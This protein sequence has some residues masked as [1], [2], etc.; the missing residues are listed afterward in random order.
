MCIRDRFPRVQE[1]V[2]SG[3]QSPSTASSL[4]AAGPPRYSLGG[5]AHGRG[6]TFRGLQL[7]WGR[8]ESRG[9]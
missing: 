3:P 8:G 7:G 1:R 9:D 6:I 4:I 5:G 2:L